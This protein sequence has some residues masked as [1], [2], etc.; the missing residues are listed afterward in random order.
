MRIGGTNRPPRPGALP[1]C[2]RGPAQASMAI[3][4]R[5]HVMG[6]RCLRQTRSAGA[7]LTQT[8]MRIQVPRAAARRRRRPVQVSVRGVI[9][10]PRRSTVG[11]SPYHTRERVRLQ[12]GDGSRQPPQ[13]CRS[14]ASE[15]ATCNRSWNA[16]TPS[17]SSLPPPLTGKLPSMN[18]ACRKPVPS[19]KPPSTTPKRC[20]PRT[21]S[22]QVN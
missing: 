11:V 3:T 7:G 8:A 4:R 1:T 14:R 2:L 9:P 22:S 20:S 16:P 15:S 6:S 17:R 18:S 13:H 19:A 5:G 10:A 12:P 21:A